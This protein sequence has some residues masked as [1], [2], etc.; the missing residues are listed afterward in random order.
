[1]GGLSAC[2]L[3]HVPS[4]EEREW[5]LED[6]VVMEELVL[7]LLQR[8]ARRGVVVLLCDCEQV[9]STPGAVG[10]ACSLCS[11]RSGATPPPLCEDSTSGS[12]ALQRASFSFSWRTSFCKASN[13]S[14]K[15]KPLRAILC[16]GVLLGPCYV[17]LYVVK[18]DFLFSVS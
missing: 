2:R 12:L 1:M 14:V 5:K 6:V 10:V 13:R 7:D 17:Q 8:C 15:A 18:K 11:E 16:L 3:A 4:P 9:F